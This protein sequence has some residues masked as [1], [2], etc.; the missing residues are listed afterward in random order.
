[1]VEH[2]KTSRPGPSA[3]GTPS[4]YDRIQKSVYFGKQPDIVK[5][6]NRKEHDL[7]SCRGNLLINDD[8]SQKGRRFPRHLFR[9]ADRERALVR[10]LLV[11]PCRAMSVSAEFVPRVKTPRRKS[12]ELVL[13]VT[14]AAP[15][16]VARL[17]RG[18]MVD[19]L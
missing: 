19:D 11:F 10:I 5:W 18:H 4:R 3:D 13:P 12:H 6:N 16:Q 7:K 14:L 15:E 17:G 9:L 2:P 8:V 1:M